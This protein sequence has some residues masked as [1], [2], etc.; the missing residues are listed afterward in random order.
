M[1][2][3]LSN[4]NLEPDVSLWNLYEAWAKGGVGTLITGNVMVDHRAMTGPG[5]VVLEEGFSLI[6]FKRWA[7]TVKSNGTKI[8]MQINHPG[9][10]ILAKLGGNV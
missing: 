5:G 7:E 2:E 3:N 8:I 6:G 4:E 10:Q 9:R 1:E